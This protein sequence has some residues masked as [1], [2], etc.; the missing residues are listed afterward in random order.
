MRNVPRKYIGLYSKR[1][2][3]R[4][5]AVRS[6]CLECVYYL[7]KEV[8]NCTDGGCPLYKWRKTG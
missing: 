3:S 6:F 1:N 4:K 7:P 5:A 8:E 2:T